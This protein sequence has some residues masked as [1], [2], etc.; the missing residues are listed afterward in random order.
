M[1]AVVGIVRDIAETS[2]DVDLALLFNRQPQ[3]NRSDQL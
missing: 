2:P 1:A 3:Y